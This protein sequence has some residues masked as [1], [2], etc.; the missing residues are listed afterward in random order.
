MLLRAA[1]TDRAVGDFV[2]LLAGRTKKGATVQ[3]MGAAVAQGWALRCCLQY[4]A[5]AH[6]FDE[7]VLT[8]A[9]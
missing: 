1:R 9:L 7:L 5:V 3:E 4:S 2:G 8:S 6:I